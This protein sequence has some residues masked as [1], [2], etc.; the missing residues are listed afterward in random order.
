MR[1]WWQRSCGQK[2]QCPGAWPAPFRRLPATLTTCP[3]GQGDATPRGKSRAL[4]L[5]PKH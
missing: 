5:E 3:P 4:A 1:S 2:W